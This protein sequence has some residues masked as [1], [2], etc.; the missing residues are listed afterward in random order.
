[1]N[2]GEVANWVAVGATTFAACV[3]AANLGS[4][5]TG[6]GFV[7]FLIGSICW[8]IYGGA[9][10]Q[11]GLLWQNVFLCFVNI[12]GIWRW[13]GRRA[14]FDEGAKAAVAESEEASSDTLFSVSMLAGCPVKAADGTVIASSV[15][16]MASARTGSI[17]YV[18]VSEGGV[19]GVSETLHLLPWNQATAAR[20][21]VGVDF[22]IDG[23]RALRLLAPDD[24]PGDPRKVRQAG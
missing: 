7:I 19:A 10:D 4:R 8:S 11:P 20:D 16:A 22:G 24:W 6:Y 9:T 21:H 2:T 18:V 14:R 3:T 23:V 12:L 17:A 15:E 5:I 1:M 13:L